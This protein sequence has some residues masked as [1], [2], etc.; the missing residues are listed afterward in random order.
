M[1]GGCIEV[2]D[3][4]M[5]NN[6]SRDVTMLETFAC[7]EVLVKSTQNYHHNLIIS[8]TFNKIFAQRAKFLR[9][10]IVHL[11]LNRFTHIP[12]CF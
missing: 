11:R 7:L 4:T 8:Q 5:M 1:S 10:L 2:W 6:R 12:I 3:N 9:S